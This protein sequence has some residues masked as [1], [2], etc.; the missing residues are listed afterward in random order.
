MHVCIYAYVSNTI[1]WKATAMPRRMNDSLPHRS[2][3]QLTGLSGAAQ[4]PG[5]M[6]KDAQLTVSRRPGLRP[7]PSVWLLAPEKRNLLTLQVI[8]SLFSFLSKYSRRGISQVSDN[9][10]SLRENGS[11]TFPSRSPIHRLLCIS[12]TSG[13]ADNLSVLLLLLAF[14]DSY[15]SFTQR[16]RNLLCVR[17]YAWP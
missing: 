4:S 5:L 17:F 12:P 14:P 9:S 2:P 8:P 3:R 13:S 7:Q 1:S 10:R 15:S 16:F 6:V 11:H